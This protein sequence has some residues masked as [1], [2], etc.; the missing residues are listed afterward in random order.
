MLENRSFDH[1]VGGLQATFPSV[2][3]VDPNKPARVNYDG[4]GYTYKQVP[5][6]TAVVDP[7]PMHELDDVLDQLDGNNAQ[8]VLNYAQSYPNTS[9]AQRQEVMGYHPRASLP[10][11]HQL[12]SIYALCNYYYA[13]VPG[14]TWPN[15]LFATSGTSKG[16]ASNHYHIYDQPSVFRRLSEA[17]RY[18]RVYRDGPAFVWLLPDVDTQNIWPMSRFIKDAKGAAS[19]FPEFAFIEPDYSKNDDHPPHDVSEGQQLVAR[20]YNAIR[21][22]QALWESTLLVITYDEHGGFYDHR[23]PPA[24]TP[25]DARKNEYTFDRYG[26]R[27]PCA[28][29]SPWIKQQIV[30]TTFDHTSLLR[31]LQV[32]WGLGSMGSRVAK[33]NSILAGVKVTTRV[34]QTRQTLAMTRR[35]GP[36]RRRH[37]L[38][39]TQRSLVILADA[40]YSRL[41][42]SAKKV[43]KTYLKPT[44]PQQ[45]WRTAEMRGRAYEK[46]AAGG[47][48]LFP[49]SRSRRS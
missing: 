9:R 11:L 44:T 40:L 18:W 39:E 22:N 19:D 4:H 43:P 7:D 38:T 1:F 15:R 21:A 12:A 35:S 46:Y 2:D 23:S 42:A 20:V 29:I 31:Y 25:P 34:R 24:A 13:S 5:T 27:V 8:F 14:P 30:N 6:V 47:K 36:V 10:A 33:A 41:P 17:Q 48:R 3:G 16:Y 49:L 37:G 45:E 26:V 28:L 32:K